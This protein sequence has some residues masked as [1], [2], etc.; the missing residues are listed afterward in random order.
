MPEMDAMYRRL[1]ER[2]V[3]GFHFVV[4]LL[5]DLGTVFHDRLSSRR[6]GV[7]FYQLIMQSNSP[8]QLFPSIRRFL[9]VNSFPPRHSIKVS[10]LYKNFRI[11]IICLQV[12]LKYY[13]G[14]SIFSS[15]Y[16]SPAE[17]KRS[18]LTEL[19]RAFP[20]ATFV[21][22]GDSAEQDLELYMEFAL[23]FPGRVAM[24][25]IRDVTSDRAAEVWQEVERLDQGG[26]TGS[27]TP[28]TDKPTPR[29]PSSTTRHIPGE[30]PARTPLLRTASSSS[31]ITEEELRSLSSTQQ[32]ILQRA[33]T[34]QNR[35]DKAQRE[36]PEGMVLRFCKDPPQVEG[37][38]TEI[39]DRFK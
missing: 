6:C 11:S 30:M 33:L 19:F 39:V 22:F 3:A 29:S 14:R 32:K 28:M 17:R 26:S 36:K 1:D 34:W 38:V 25:A 4:S 13:G 2:G 24:V 16:D 23:K 18:S 15:L 7:S 21:M 35:M 27:S 10:T 5:F 9:T 31:A 37:E 20:K 8:S 12:Q